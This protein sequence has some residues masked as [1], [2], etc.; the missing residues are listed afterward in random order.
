M[1]RVDVGEEG[2]VQVADVRVFANEVSSPFDLVAIERCTY[3][4]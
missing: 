2:R 4:R 1:A 3:L